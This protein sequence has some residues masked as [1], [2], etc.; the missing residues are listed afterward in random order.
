MGARR[1]PARAR[2]P[3][4]KSKGWRGP[5]RD[6]LEIV[7]RPKVRVRA[8]PQRHLDTSAILKDYGLLYPEALELGAP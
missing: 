1:P 6:E 2:A 3:A 4:C 8:E 7:Y 5:L